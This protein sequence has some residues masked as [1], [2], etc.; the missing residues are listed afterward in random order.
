MLR[1]TIKPEKRLY[2]TKQR[3]QPTPAEAELW[4]HLCNKQLG[5]RFRRQAILRGYIA[6]FWAPRVRL[7][8]EADGP[9]HE[10]RKNYDENRDRFFA[11]VG[12]L[13]LRFSNPEILNNILDVIQR[14]RAVVRERLNAGIKP[15]GPY[16]FMSRQ[17]SD[18]QR[19]L[20]ASAR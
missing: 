14:I 4:K 16:D 18:H 20:L 12:I 2:A 1:N 8:V 19:L 3:E 10:N 5:I 9:Y 6:D 11:H 17:S 13:T 7:I 15:I